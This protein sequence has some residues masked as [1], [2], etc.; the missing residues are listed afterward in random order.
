[1]SV[2]TDDDRPFMSI[3]S[4]VYMLDY[5]WLGNVPDIDVE[6]QYKRAVQL[7]CQENQREWRRFG[8]YSLYSNDLLRLRTRNDQSVQNSTDLWLNDAVSQA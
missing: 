7:C 2:K 3:L 4:T 8:G 6:R 1:M 5:K